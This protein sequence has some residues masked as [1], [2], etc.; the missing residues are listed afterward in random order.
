M[1]MVRLTDYTET[2][3]VA[4]YDL[5]PGDID[6]YPFDIAG[7]NAFYENF[8]TVSCSFVGECPDGIVRNSCSWQ[9][10]FGA[11]C[12]GGNNPAIIEL[13]LDVVADVN[14]FL[15]GI[16]ELGQGSVLLQI[17]SQGFTYQATITNSLPNHCY[18]VDHNAPVGSAFDFNAYIIAGVFNPNILLNDIYLAQSL[19][20]EADIDYVN[21]LAEDQ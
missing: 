17:L 15:V 21:F 3:T 9:R 7:T 18:F 20:G 1:Q 14:P 2:L 11:F 12:L 8:E 6:P 4:G 19:G 13:M 5:Y 10:Y 16:L